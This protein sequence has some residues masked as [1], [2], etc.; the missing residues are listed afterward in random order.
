VVSIHKK[1][2]PTDMDNYRGISFMSVPLK[3]LLIILTYRIA[4][5]LEDE[6]LL[7]REQAGF[8]E[9]EECAGQVAALVEA[10]LRRSG[11]GQATFAMFVDLTKA[12]DVGLE[13]GCWSLFGIFIVSLRLSWGWAEVKSPFDLNED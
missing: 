10:A 1:G 2:D 8:R 4:G 3:L 7:A 9:K 13:A 6:G 12:Y 11:E 5:G